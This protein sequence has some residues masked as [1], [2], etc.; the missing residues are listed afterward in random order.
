MKKTETDSIN[1][2]TRKQEFNAYKSTLRRLINQ[3]KK[4]YFSGQFLKQRGNGRKTWQTIDNALHRKSNRISPN[5]ILIDRDICTNKENM[6]NAF[7][8]YFANICTTIQAPNDNMI[9]HTSYLNT[10]VHS[11]FKFKTINNA[12]TLQYLSNLMNSY[13]AVA[14]TILIIPF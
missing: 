10:S 6:A 11:T 13:T 2:E 7:N 9:S 8:K 5:A 14:M 3:A 1:Y 12:T 4:L